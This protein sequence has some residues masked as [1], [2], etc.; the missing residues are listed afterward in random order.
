MAPLTPA[1]EFPLHLHV[2]VLGL[3]DEKETMEG[4]PG[5]GPQ[6]G[7]GVQNWHSPCAASPGVRGSQPAASPPAG[8]P[9]TA[10]PA[11]PVPGPECS[12]LPGAL[13]ERGSVTRRGSALDSLQPAR[14][15]SRM[16]GRPWQ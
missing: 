5:M 13:V 4:C 10:V 14:G 16:L 11:A 3:G 9:G 2:E 1:S 6:N 8:S 15:E 12:Q 7:V